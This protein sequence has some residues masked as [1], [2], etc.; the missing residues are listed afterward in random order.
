M[1]MDADD[2]IKIVRGLDQSGP[3]EDGKNLD[4][5][6]SKLVASSDESFHAAEESTLRWLLKVMNGNATTAEA[7]RRHPLTWTM[8][9]C[10]FARI[11]L[12]SLAKSLADRKFV[13]VLQQTLKDIS[14]V[15]GDNTEHTAT[16]KRKRSSPAPFG[17]DETRQPHGRLST[18]K[19]LLNTLKSLL[20]R[21]DD[22]TATTARDNIGAE[23]IRSLFCMSAVDTA[24]LLVPV[25]SVCQLL[26]DTEMYDTEGAEEWVAVA[27]SL[28]SLHMQG[29]DDMSKAAG[30]LFTT[31]ASILSDL[32]NLSGKGPSNAPTTL[33]SKWSADL[34]QFLQR[35][36][37]LPCRT[38]FLNRQDFAAITVALGASEEKIHFTAPSLY[39]LATR[40]SDTNAE[41]ERR[42]NAVE[43]MKRVFEEIEKA[44]HDNPDRN[45]LIELIL[46]Q[47]IGNSTPVDVKNL[48][49]IARGYVLEQRRTDWTLLGSIVTCDPAVFQTS[50]DGSDLLVSICDKISKSTSSESQQPIAEVLGAIRQSFVIRR[51]LVAFLQLWFTELRKAE[52][53]GQAKTSPWFGEGPKHYKGKYLRDLIEKELSASQLSEFVAWL[54]SQPTQSSPNSL[55]AINDTISKGLKRET[56]IDAVDLRLFQMTWTACAE[57]ADL[58]ARWR[59]SSKTMAWAKPDGR[60][61]VW[62]SLK[63]KV[64]QTLKKGSLDAEDTFECFRFCYSAWDALTTDADTVKE[65]TKLIQNFSERLAKK[66][67]SESAIQKITILDGADAEVYAFDNQLPA[68]CYLDVFLSGGSRFNRLFSMSNDTVPEPLKN[69]ITT[70]ELATKDKRVLWQKVF[71]NDINLNEAKLARTLVDQVIDA[72]DQLGKEKGWPGSDATLIIQILSRIP[73]DSFN[74]WQREKIVNTLNKSSGKMIKSPEK[75][76]LASWKQILSLVTKLMARATFYDGMTF[77]HLVILAEAVSV[78]MA[79]TSTSDEET[80]E[81]IER[82][83]QMASSVIRQMADQVDERST[84]YFGECSKYITATTTSNFKQL[85]GLHY[86]LIKSL[87][88]V[89]SRSPNTQNNDELTKLVAEGQSMLAKA[90]MSVINPLITAKALPSAASSKERLELLAATDAAPSAAPL[91]QFYNGKPAPLQTFANNCSSKMVEGDVLAWKVQILLRNELPAALQLPAPKTFDAL[92]PLPRK[93]QS[94]L[95]CDLTNSITKSLRVQE[96]LAYLRDLVDALRAGCFTDS[97]TLAIQEVVS[98]LVSSPEYQGKFEGYDLAAAYSEIV[99]LL[100]KAPAPGNVSLC[101]TLHSL[102]E[103]K[104]QAVSQWDVEATLSTICELCPV[105]GTGGLPYV[106]LCR[107][108]DVIIKKHR[109]RLE[110]HYHLLLTVLQALLERLVVGETGGAGD[111]SREAK[112]HAYARLIT[113]VC[114]PTAGAVSR[115]Q[116]Q[117]SLDS[118]T[119]VAKRSA[120]RHMHLV[121]MR[122]VQLQLTEDVPRPLREALEPAMNSIFDITPPEGRK[123]LNDAMDASGR[124][125]LR[126]MFKRYVKFGK[127]SGV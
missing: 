43:W 103:R 116:H 60:T 119:D 8:L 30:L 105:Q 106:W 96:K 58:P 108:T 77:D 86:S 11:P 81:M 18:A 55:C 61:V 7:M 56:F 33:K 15:A 4:L 66:V 101:R 23:H 78:C 19:S 76:L 125:I 22:A 115:T 82:F 104:P 9:D 74:R 52:E 117:S 91:A 51:D 10:V 120:G 59:I 127:W 57:L 20:D 62:Q 84:K 35:S 41:G 73:L 121:L 80:L 83:S 122:Y 90:I 70:S 44:V 114:E 67:M 27:S 16:K 12:F 92:S 53:K 110:G 65:P 2:L 24:A 124:A 95:L 48:R 63:D 126:E 79:K 113:L 46:R 54:E 13:A 94:R 85:H 39:F 72:L 28:W 68:A 3:G 45:A 6:W 69:A 98:Q 26:I 29:D 99:T 109:L 123:I 34:Q 64:K 97:Q 32:E 47:A 102:L 87:L 1:T 89:V 112:A 36:L 40:S 118:A 17:S 93:L 71:S 14:T 38:T 5:L 31:P 50:G 49:E 42:K 25:F 100:S 111:A 75:T 107:L 37:I 88:S 21:L